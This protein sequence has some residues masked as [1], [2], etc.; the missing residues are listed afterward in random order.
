MGIADNI[1]GNQRFFTVFEHALHR[2]FGC[3]PHRSIDILGGRIFSQPAHKIHNRTVRNGNPHGQTIQFALQPGQNLAHRPGRTRGCGDNVFT[4]SSAAP[5]I[6]VGHIGQALI[7]GIG[8]HRGDEP[9]FEAERIINNFGNRRQAV[10]GTGCIRD[11]AVL[12]FKLI[13]VD[14]Q[15]NGRIDFLFGRYREKDFFGAGSQMFFQGRSFAKYAGGFDDDI[16]P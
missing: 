13:I 16:N 1:T 9:F 4:G 5:E 3:F 7:V 14:T 15:H 12:R 8:M 2:S 6:F 10:G 11:D